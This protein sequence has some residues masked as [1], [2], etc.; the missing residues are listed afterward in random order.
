MNSINK[1]KI[2]RD[3]KLAYNLK[4]PQS[5]ENV[6]VKIKDIIGCPNEYLPVPSLSSLSSSSSSSSSSSDPSSSSSS[7]FSVPSSHPA[8]FIIGL[9]GDNHIAFFDMDSGALLKYIF[10]AH[11]CK[12][13]YILLLL[14]ILLLCYIIL[15]NKINFR[16][17]DWNVMNKN[18]VVTSTIQVSAPATTFHT[19]H[20]AIF[21]VYPVN[22]I[23]KFRYQF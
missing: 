16:Y 22:L 19:T 8:T 7:L 18:F 12:F 10:L 4:L 15:Y 3:G 2:N 11:Q 20:F 21:E 1:I 5:E 9:T 17:I 23:A 13:R 14:F 6:N